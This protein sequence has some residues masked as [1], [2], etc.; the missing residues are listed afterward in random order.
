MSVLSAAI[1]R[2]D[3]ALYVDSLFLVFII[4]IIAWIVISWVVMF[5]GSLPYNQPLRAVTGFVEECV[6]PYLNVFRRMVPTVGVGGMGLD[7][8]P[9]V[10]LIFLFI[11][12]AITVGLISG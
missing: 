8:G 6:E 7:L 5:R 2:D 11:L 4:M 12:R 9:M 3:V 1:D 10:G